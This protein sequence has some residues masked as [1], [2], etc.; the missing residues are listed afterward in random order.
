MLIKYLLG[1][2]CAFI[3]GWSFGF[4]ITVGVIAAIFYGW[5]ING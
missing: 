2:M 1:G 4:K 3:M 5:L